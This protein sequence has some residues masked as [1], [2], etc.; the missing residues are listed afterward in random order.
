MGLFGG[1]DKADHPLADPKEA[2]RLLGAFATATD[3]HK[4]L[5]EITEWIESVM[6]AEDFKPDDYA[7]LVLLLDETGQ[8]HARKLTREYLGNAR[9]LKQEESKLWSANHDFWKSLST[10]YLQSVDLSI[11][12]GKG[13][14]ALKN[15]LPLIGARAEKALA[16]QLKWLQMRYGP[17]HGDLWFAAGRTYRHLK[18]KRLHQKM[19]AVYPG[20]AGES[21]TEQEFLKLLMFAASSPDSMVPEEIELAERVIAYFLPN[22]S[23]TDKPEPDTTYWL[24]LDEADPPLRLAQ[25][26][27]LTETLVFFSAG[28]AIQGVENMATNIESRKVIPTELKLVGV[29]QLEQVVE[30]LEH[31]AMYWAKTPPIRRHE[32]HR[33]KARLSVVH[34]YAGLL[35]C[36]AWDGSTTD[37]AIH[38]G[39]TIESWVV[40]NV[41]AGGFGATT[42]TVT[43]DWLKIG[44]VV[45]LQPSGGENWLVGIVRRLARDTDELGN[46]GIQT[47]AK[48]ARSIELRAGGSGTSLGVGILL[49]DPSDKAGEVRVLLEPDRFDSRR[50]IEITDDGGTQL[51]MP[52]ELVERSDDYE[53]AKY[54]GMKRT[55]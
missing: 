15:A 18:A 44:S 34:G 26:P 27:E 47:V 40:Q 3:S 54:R 55:N 25:P 52:I 46:V 37:L 50:S 9:L 17:V 22:F 32:R 45:G 29:Y 8:V 1:R 24:D 21:S 43:G 36:L 53:L 10:A 6:N 12:N 4:A 20:V 51:L 49:S 14:D 2:K 5:T 19:V 48:S 42:P 16:A 28:T 23:L 30:V 38:G 31:L 33:V 13:S 39:N 11:D 35:A 41:S 7:N